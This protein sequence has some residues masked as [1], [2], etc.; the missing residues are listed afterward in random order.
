MCDFSKYGIPSAEWLR[1]EATLP[2]VRDQSLDDWKTITNAGREV[3][4]RNAMES[5]SDKVQ[6]HD[7]S[8]PTHDGY[9]LEV[10]SYRPTSIETNEVLPIYVHFHGGG[11]LFGTLSSE[12]ASCSRIA[13]NVGVVVVNVNYRHTPE[14]TYPTAWNDS[15]DALVWIWNNSILFNGD[16]DRLVIGGISAGA[17]LTAALAQTISRSGLNVQPPLRVLGQVLMIPCLVFT[18]CYESQI[19]QIKDPSVSSYVQCAEA[20]ILNSRRKK[21]FNDLLKVENPSAED[22]RL[23]P[24]N[25]TPE[26][27]REL[28]PTTL[29]I[30][31]Y[32]PLRDEGILYGKLL[33]ENG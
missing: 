20:P 6:V 14:Y 26:E 5:L 12:D 24:G 23:N 15:E 18:A 7:Y 22:K 17:W 3:M 28:P 9:M 33:A 25:V 4:A 31:G 21:L 19:R 2:V 8:I 16:R 32:D 10:R 1:V 27:A 30:A 13:I 29:G 11:F